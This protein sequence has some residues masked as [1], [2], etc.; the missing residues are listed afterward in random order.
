MS[1]LNPDHIADLQKSGLSDEMIE[2]AGIYSVPP[3]QINEIMGWDAP[4]NSMLAFPYPGADCTRYKL[5]PPLKRKDETRAQKY[6]Q[7][8]GSGLHL[9]QSPVFDPDA[10]DIYI[11]EGEKKALKACQNGLNCL[12]LSGLWNWKVKSEDALIA[13]FDLFNFKGKNIYLVPDN[14]WQ[15]P[16]KNLSQAVHRLAYLLRER[17]AIV[18][19][20]ELPE[21]SGKVGLD[22]YLVSHTVEKFH[23][24]PII[25]VKSL[26]ERVA[27]ATPEN[28]KNVLPEIKTI[29]DVIERAI[30]CK[31]L[32]KKIGVP[33]SVIQQSVTPPQLEAA[34]DSIVEDV[35]PLETP[36]DGGE[37]LNTLSEVIGN[38]VVMDSSA[39]TSCAL[40]VA[41]TYCYDSFRILP[42][43]AISSPEKRC[44]KTTLLEILAGLTNKPLLASNITP[45]AI[46]RTIE[47]HQP[48]L[49]IDEAD[50]F[51]KDNEEL[52]GL[53]NS[54]H[55]RKSAFVIRTNLNT[56]EVERF[57][58]WG[59]KAIALIGGLPGTIIDRSISVRLERKTTSEKVTKVSIDF[60]DKHMSLR[61][62]MKRW[63]IDNAETLKTMTPEIPETGNDRAA[64]NWTPLLS[65]AE[66]AG[67]VWPDRARQS[68]LALEKV[69][70]GDSIRQTLLRDIKEILGEQERIFSKDLVSKLTAIEDHPWGDWRKGK[71]IT[72]NGLARLLKPFNIL[73]K[74]IRIG[75][76]T[77]KGYTLEQFIDPF[78][79]YLPSTPP[80]QTATTPQ[81]TLTKQLRGFQ[82]ATQDSNVA[83]ENRREPTPVEE[84]G[85]VA[86]E[87]VVQAGTQQGEGQEYVSIP[88]FE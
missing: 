31:A 51:L 13:D 3:A 2:K 63:A 12:G 43:L 53:V 56:M 83:V 88:Y 64:D 36:V 21:G 61:R 62:K 84:C 14:D 68:M 72:Q 26:K 54:G 79:R 70:D 45:S 35:E 29:Q 77:P 11:T 16:D 76:R 86:V 59:P 17:G 18:S 47:A 4:I 23:A 34:T 28:Y 42:I 33:V 6:F 65:I 8:K 55:T 46:F 24:L 32:A 7:P 80:V 41:L 52:R 38:H 40:W 58:T 60:D 1:K 25:Q 22:D 87:Q 49:L 81:P 5:F 71:P 20:I 37:L 48:C 27:E 78:K 50:T 69:S 73:P 74:T 9:Y 66:T 19:I 44:G 10:G 15:A 39:I 85:V 30:L 82:S 57:S 67:G 75:D